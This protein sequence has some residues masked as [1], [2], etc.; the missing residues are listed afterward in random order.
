ME[1]IEIIQELYMHIWVNS[2]TWD[3]LSMGEQN[4]IIGNTVIGLM[5]WLWVI[6]SK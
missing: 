3:Q 4:R 6:K 5:L 1:I 2:R